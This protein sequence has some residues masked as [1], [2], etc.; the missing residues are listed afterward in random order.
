MKK[1]L[2]VLVLIPL[3]LY[4]QSEDDK[5]SATPSLH[6]LRNL[7]VRPP[8]RNPTP[9]PPA[10]EIL[11]QTDKFFSTLKEGN[12]TGAYNGLLTDTRLAERKEQVKVLIDKTTQALGI[13]GKISSYEIYDDYKVGSSLVVL[14]YLTNMQIQPIRWRLIFYKADKNWTLIDI[15]VFDSLEDLVE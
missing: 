15:S 2:L 9:V 1:I 6:D 5:A 12:V 10:P 8:R 11:A 13:Y 7:L 14:T 4:A 3:C